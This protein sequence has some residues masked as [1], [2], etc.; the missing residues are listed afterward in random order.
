MFKNNNATITFNNEIS[1]FMRNK[2]SRNVTIDLPFNRDND[3]N[4]VEKICECMDF[5]RINWHGTGAQAKKYSHILKGKNI[6][7]FFCL[8]GAIDTVID[9][10]YIVDEFFKLPV[11]AIVINNVDSEG[12]LSSLQDKIIKIVH[13]FKHSKL[14]VYLP[15]QPE[16]CF[17]KKIEAFLVNHKIIYRYYQL[18]FGK[19]KSRSVL[20]EITCAPCWE[21]F[22]LKITRDG[23][24]FLCR[25]A[26]H[27]YPVKLFELSIDGII[28]F[29]NF[30]SALNLL[31]M[32]LGPFRTLMLLMHLASEKLRIILSHDDYSIVYLFYEQIKDRIYAPIG[33]QLCSDRTISDRQ[34]Q[35]QGASFNFD[36]VTINSAC[37]FCKIIE[38]YDFSG[39]INSLDL[40]AFDLENAL[41]IYKT[42]T[43]YRLVR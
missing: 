10:I 26:S 36:R 20:S 12:L 42:A 23:D 33:W 43:S 17:L 35:K 37:D 27:K 30:Y 11:V 5:M 21:I 19:N 16:N 3:L 39:I 25:N 34:C 31:I 18:C 32:I 7:W 6:N 13:E 4:F 29:N 22:H 40:S 8:N 24:I 15:E 9:S 1:E 28:N 2:I 38:K 41:S 14:I